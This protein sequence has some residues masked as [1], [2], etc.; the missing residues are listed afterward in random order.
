MTDTTVQ[1]V[2]YTATDTTDSNTVIGTVQVTFSNTGTTLL[3]AAPSAPNPPTGTTAT[4][5]TLTATLTDTATGAPIANA[6]VT[7]TIS[8]T[9][10]AGCTV[11]TNASGVAT[12]AG[13]AAAST[14]VGTTYTVGATFATATVGG[15][16]YATAAGSP[17][18]Y[19]TV[20]GTLPTLA[21]SAP[22]PFP[23]SEP[24]NTEFTVAAGV[25]PTADHGA[26]TYSV[27]GA[28]TDSTNITGSTRNVLMQSGTGTCYVTASIAE[29]CTASTRG[30]CTAAYGAATVT[31]AVTGTKLTPT[32]AIPPGGVPSSAG[33][34]STFAVPY[35]LSGYPTGNGVASPT[36]AVTFAVTGNCTVSGTT[37][38]MTASTGQCSITA[39]IAADLNYNSATSAPVVV[40]AATGTGTVVVTCSNF[41]YNGTAPTNP[42]SATTTPSGLEVD[43]TYNGSA[44]VPTNAG[45]YTVVGTINDPNYQGTGT[46]GL[47]ISPAPVTA[48]AVGI[49]SFYTGSPITISSCSVTGSY[50][51]PLTC[52]GSPSTET[53][54]GSGTVVPVVSYGGDL[55]TNYSVTSVDSTWTINQASSSVA[56]TCPSPETYTGSAITTCTAVTTNTNTPTDTSA[57]DSSLTP[58]IQYA[59]NINVGTAAAVATFL[60]NAN[61]APSSS[62]L[63]TFTITALPATIMLSNLTEAYT[64]NQATV[65]V[66]TNPVDNATTGLPLTWTITYSSATY[67]ASSTPPVEPGSY[68][69]VATIT[70]P[71]YAGST[72]NQVL[73]I[74]PITP[75][76]ILSLDPGD[77]AAPFLYGS[78]VSFDLDVN[79]GTPPPP[80]PSG[81]VQFYVNGVASGSQVTLDPTSC[82]SSVFYQIATLPLGTDTIYAIY[83]GDANYPQ[84]QSNTLTE[85]VTADATTVSLVST[86]GTI[87]INVGGVVTFTATVDPSP[88]ID[89]GAS[90]PGGTVS[91]YE[92]LVST[93]PPPRPA[94]LQRHPDGHRPTFI[95]HIALHRSVGEPPSGCGNVG[96]RRCLYQHR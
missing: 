47:T 38:T 70:D 96:H 79:N 13:T 35:Q 87:P 71:D 17:A 69:V 63:A 19:I 45:T 77:P 31:K 18:Q 22:S 34:E 5:E 30:V 62:T 27:T 29:Y 14:V 15:V 50:V 4:P 48:T 36:G 3:L 33:D 43:F 20:G 59:N 83:T 6:S 76:M 66:T 21:F 8:G 68:T 67:P 2:T 58:T 93:P 24:Y 73:T 72:G 61:V 75:A 82:N 64:G 88:S 40:V 49:T 1:N 41:T 65:G 89:S 37:V 52:T 42:C 57:T 28:C 91:F 80:C 10:S 92:C 39:T 12:C 51:G 26:I 86:A 7:F 60:G 46:A 81:K 11:L 85:T 32:I 94:I 84:T 56:L 53:N 44:T 55:T 78:A 95:D 90:G 54:I 16:T 23:T 9:G 74:G 25:T